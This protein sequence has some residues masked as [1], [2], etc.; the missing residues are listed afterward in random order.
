MSKLCQSCGM[1]L[2]KDPEQGGSNI[3][4]TLSTEYCS[5][6]YKD[7]EFLAADITAKEMQEF[8]VKK[9]QEMGF[10]KFLAWLMTRN[11]PKLKRWKVL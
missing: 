6:C 3:D 4:G 2:N 7:G 8:C 10:P 11:I 5:Y 1:P 9:M